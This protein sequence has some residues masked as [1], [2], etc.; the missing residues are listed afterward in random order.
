VVF[1]RNAIRFMSGEP[2]SPAVHSAMLDVLAQ[3]AA[4]PGHG[5]TYV[6][7]GTA[8]DRLGR[9]GVVIGQEEADDAGPHYVGVQSLIFDP[10]T[11]ALLDV[12]NAQ[13][14]IKMGAI[15]RT[16]GQCVPTDYTEFSAPK[17]VSA[18]PKYRAHIPGLYTQAGGP[19][20]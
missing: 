13:C 15:P 19:Y 1:V 3:I 4:H 14:E 18:V 5:Y 10:S 11:G 16:S 6:D 9:T 7:M 17:A 8:T 20:V 12:A 2:L